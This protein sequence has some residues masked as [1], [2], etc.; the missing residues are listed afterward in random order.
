MLEDV[1]SAILKIFTKIEIFY[2]IRN[3]QIFQSIKFHSNY[4]GTNFFRNYVESSFYIIFAVI[5][6]SFTIIFALHFPFSKMQA[7][8]I[9]TDCYARI[10]KILNWCIEVYFC[11]GWNWLLLFSFLVLGLWIRGPC[12][13]WRNIYIISLIPWLLS[14][15]LILSVAFAS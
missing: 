6:F 3:A 11:F 8:H 15:Q 14:V 9:S 7:G 13:L 2:K 5:L 12:K 4:V 10:F 1:I